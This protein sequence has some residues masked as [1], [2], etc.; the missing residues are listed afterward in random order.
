MTLTNFTQE[1]SIELGWW[2]EIITAFPYCT[3]YFGP[4]AT[5]QEA[6][7]AQLGYT[8]DLKQEGAYGISIQI[9]RCQPKELTTC[10]D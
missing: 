3:Y 5:Q 8:E 7:A 2:V 1:D 9:K 6:D 10:R 4:F